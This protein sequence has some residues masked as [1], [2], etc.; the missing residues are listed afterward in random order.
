MHQSSSLACEH[1][2]DELD[3]RLDVEE[4]AKVDEREEILDGQISAGGGGGGGSDR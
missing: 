2:G 1:G 4:G 3:L